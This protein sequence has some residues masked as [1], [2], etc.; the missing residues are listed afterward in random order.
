MMGPLR[1]VAVD[2]EPLA[3]RRIELLLGRMRGVELVG[4]SLDGRLVA[5]LVA[6]LRPD[7][8]LL[9]VKMPGFNGF[10]VVNALR[11]QRAPQVIF[12]TAF[13]QFAVRAFE[14]SAIDYVLKP[15]DSDR[16]AAAID[17]ARRA[18]SA[19][20]AESRVAELQ[21]V[22]AALRNASAPDDAPRFETELWAE[23]RGELTRI[24]VSSVDL[25][26]AQGDY[27][28]LHVGRHGYMLRETLAGLQARLDPNDFVRIRRSA[29]VRRDRIAG[30]R[31]AAY[32]DLRVLLANG[33]QIRI[34]R[35]YVG[36][37]RALAGRAMAAPRALRPEAA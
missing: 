23:R 3:L 19:A 2:D 14:A 33:D 25:V 37:I 31:R 6:R 29:L 9:D 32:G 13:D 12:V 17:K 1:V 30:I 8:L 21:A 34:G 22:V 18:I 26:E 16:L 11:D 7:L 5:D 24:L 4:Q 36:Q 10:E 27:V 35:T 28:K 20:D 15:V